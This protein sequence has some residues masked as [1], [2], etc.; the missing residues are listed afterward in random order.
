MIKTF[1]K[2]LHVTLYSNMP[3]RGVIGKIKSVTNNVFM[4]APIYYMMEQI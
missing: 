3:G 1:Y 4:L 2:T